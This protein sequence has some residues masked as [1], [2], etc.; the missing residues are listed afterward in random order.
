MAGVPGPGSGVLEVTS[1]IQEK[2]YPRPNRLWDH[3]KGPLVGPEPRLTGHTLPWIRPERRKPP[4]GLSATLKTP[5]QKT[6]RR[7]GATTAVES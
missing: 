5:L 6:A 1:G 4:K 2:Y 3:S 7:Q